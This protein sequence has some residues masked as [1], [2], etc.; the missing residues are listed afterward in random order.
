MKKTNTRKRI[1]SILM[2][3]MMVLS[4]L[5]VAT[6]ASVPEIDNSTSTIN[7]PVS[8]T[9]VDEENENQRPESI[10]VNLMDGEEN[11]SSITI[12]A[13][14]DWKGAFKNVPITR[15]GAAIQY[16]ITEQPVL[17]Y[18]T[19]YTQ[20][21]LTPLSVG[22]WGEKITPASNPTY[23]FTGD[24]IVANKG[25]NYFIWTSDALNDAQKGEVLAA[26]KNAELQGLGNTLTLNNTLF[27]NSLPASFNNGTVTISQTDNGKQISFSETNVWS[28]FYVGTLTMPASTEAI[29]TNTYNTEM[30]EED[31]PETDPGTLIVQKMVSGN[32]ADTAKAFTFEVRVKNPPPTIN[33]VP[34]IHD[35]PNIGEPSVDNQN[36]DN[37]IVYNGITFKN[38]GD[39]L[40]GTFSLKHNEKMEFKDIP[41]GAEYTV[42]EIDNDGY[43]VSV[44][45]Q[46]TDHATGT[47]IA[48]N[49]ETLIFKNHKESGYTPGPY[50]P[51]TYPLTITKQV[52]GLDSIPAGY[53]V[54]VD[55]T[56]KYGT[57]VRTVT[58]KANETTTIDLPYGEYTL[59]EASAAVEAY[60]QSGQTF[61]ENNF[62]LT[63]GG[64]SVTITNTYT[65]DAEGPAIDPKPTDPESIDLPT[66]LE[67]DK[68]D[69][70]PNNVPKTS[71]D[72]PISLTLYGILAAGALLGIR[73]ALKRETK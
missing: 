33:A 23:S 7:I 52:V 15:N 8:K 19:T 18:T 11:F 12:N 72:M 43:N 14:N 38:E 57:L 9:W 59:A 34:L 69:E 61:S 48:G 28:L 53:S 21:V 3:F 49:T 35:M 50:Y 37:D 73:K 58:L 42:T 4:L 32:G 44:N 45:D 5:P 22:S 67:E 41:V 51:S 60:K 16:T 6:F 20:P 13:D 29:I 36:N 68:T 10:T 66:P 39:Y 54:A 1:F 25:G 26:V 27:A 2:L 65:K 24:I 40:V 17:N 64:K 56:N 30:Q 71:D 62:T 55:I 70:N 47:I 46:S 63:Y 31:E